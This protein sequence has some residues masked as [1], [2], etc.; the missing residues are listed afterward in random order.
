MGDER[1]CELA[2]CAQ[3]DPD[4][5]MPDAG[6]SSRDAITICVTCP[7]RRECLNYALETHPS[8]GIWAGYTIK[9]LGQL[10]VQRRTA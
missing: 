5:W 4:L 9:Q 7:V 3:T 6:Q 1:W 2:S 10:R 8:H